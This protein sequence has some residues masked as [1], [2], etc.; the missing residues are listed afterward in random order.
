[1]NSPPRLTSTD[2]SLRGFGPST[3][4]SVPNL[5]RR[6]F[7]KRASSDCFTGFSRLGPRGLLKCDNPDYMLEQRP[8]D[9]W[10]SGPR[11]NLFHDETM[12]FDVL[13]AVVLFA[14]GR[15]RAALRLDRA[16]AQPG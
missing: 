7:C 1:M 11:E 16:G 3:I 4:R 2:P 8:N 5:S 13:G 6:Y 10:K 14:R 9:Q 15:D 12:H